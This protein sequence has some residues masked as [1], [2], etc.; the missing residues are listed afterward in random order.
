M[1]LFFMAFFAIGLC[2]ASTFVNAQTLSGRITGKILD[3]NGRSVEGATVS[4]ICVTDSVI[5]KYE[6]AAADGGFHFEMIKAGAYH[7]RISS[8]GKLPYKSERIEIDAQHQMVRL[9]VIVMHA[10]TKALQEVMVISKK[11]FLEQKIDRTVVNVD[12]QI[13]NAGTTALEVLEKSPGVNVSENGAISLHGKAG[14]TI[15]I[16]DKPT[17]LSG[18]D[19][20]NY[21]RS[22]PSS[23]LS[24]IELMT[25]PPAKYDAAGTGGIIN[26]K[27]KKTKLTGFNLGMNLSLRQS[28]Y[29]ETNNSMDFNYRKDKINVFGTLAYTV[30]NS[31]NDVDIN[32]QYFY[33]A[34][35]PSGAF[36]QN[37]YIRRQGDGYKATLG[38]D[39][40]TSEQTTLGVLLTGLVRSPGNRNNSQGQLYNATY[41]A[42][43]SI[44]SQ[45]N[46]QGKFKN[47][48]ANLNYKHT[49]KKDGPEITAN[50][51]YLAF[52]TDN[53]Q[54]FLNQNYNAA[55]ILSSADQLNGNLPAAIHIYAAKVDYS[56]PVAKDWKLEAGAKSSYTSTDNQADYVNIVG[57]NAT[58]DYDKTNH[59][60]YKEDINAGYLNLNKDFKRLSIQAGLRL[61]NTNSRGHQLGNVQKPDSAFNRNY[62]SLFPTLYLLY[63][64]DTLGDH[65][66][67][68]TYG[69]RI[70]RPY[71]QDLN[72]F[73]SPLDKYTY[74]TGNPYLLPSYSKNY[75]LGYIY[76]D[77][78]TVTL[79]YMDI[80]NRVTETID[81]R[82][83]Y[84]YDRP[85]N[86]G[87]TKI[88]DLNVDAGFDPTS[89]FSL[90][91]SGDVWQ[92]RQNSD[93]YTGT[94]ANHSLSFS[95]QALLQFKLKKG[96]TLQTDGKYQGKQTDAQF[97]IAA[98]GRWNAA[99][100][101]VLSPKAT[102]KFSIS[103]LLY[104]NINKGTIGSLYQTSASFRTLTDSRAA[105]LTLSMR[106]GKSV[107]GQRKHNQTGAGEENDR[108]K[109]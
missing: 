3:E 16:D 78:I 26:I 104:T 107:A 15:Y 80:G 62:T 81:I 41:Q 71:Y 61:E 89:W 94:L 46:E 11:H 85:G 63:K 59:F 100:S 86:I 76:K 79:S 84:Y 22:M 106:F 72:P 2:F 49:F 34:G 47:G 5:V 35:Q 39:I 60:L 28:R 30:R 66:L 108:V 33:N 25:N 1:K 109:N 43:S 7:I 92:I 48:T 64:L 31:F 32:R 10:D 42:D 37:S 75:E 54:V 83:G 13:S 50:L 51:D 21:L 68:L 65:Q 87:N 44:V 57:G 95:G 55:G 96:W 36:R 6:P 19:L 99:V 38:M 101:K 18:S 58:A 82:N 56:Q 88:Y 74:Y 53:N 103:D 29:T 102:L 8:T 97:L 93:F 12:A 91:L 105:L 73:I 27:T 90:Q 52:A 77:R 24:Q 67:K 98:R 9:P 4:L 17:Y 69:R 23:M 70:E 20:Q 14:V 45:N 40:F